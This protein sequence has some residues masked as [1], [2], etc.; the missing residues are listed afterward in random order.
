MH[1]C[2]L[3]KILLIG[4]PK[5]DDYKLYMEKITEILKQNSIKSITCAHMEVPCCFGFVRIIK[6]AI[7]DSGKDIS[8]REINISIKGD[9]IS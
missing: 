5:F 8:L 3:G 2:M 7:T 9:T 6:E 1:Q 4:C